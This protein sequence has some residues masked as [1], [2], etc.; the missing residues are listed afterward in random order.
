MNALHMQGKN[1]V[2]FEQDI[3]NVCYTPVRYAKYVASI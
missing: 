1:M 2:N 3:G